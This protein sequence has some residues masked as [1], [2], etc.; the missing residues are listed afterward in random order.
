MDIVCFVYPQVKAEFGKLR[1]D[2]M[3]AILEPR[4]DAEVRTLLPRVLAK[5]KP[6]LWNIMPEVGYTA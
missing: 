6:E 1:P 2:I 5:H 3:A 4:L